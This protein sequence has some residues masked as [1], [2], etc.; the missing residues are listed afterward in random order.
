MNGNVVLSNGWG[1]HGAGIYISARLQ[2]QE[3]RQVLCE[4]M[5]FKGALLRS[6]QSCDLSVCERAEAEV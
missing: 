1:I 6:H 4:C 2:S 5:V 3:V